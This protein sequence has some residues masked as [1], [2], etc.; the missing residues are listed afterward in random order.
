MEIVQTCVFLRADRV[1]VP[2]SSEGIE[3]QR[4]DITVKTVISVNTLL[5]RLTQPKALY[6]VWQKVKMHFCMQREPQTADVPHTEIP[7][8]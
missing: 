4:E 1:S 8:G 6:Y 3:T 7:S 5:I 2:S